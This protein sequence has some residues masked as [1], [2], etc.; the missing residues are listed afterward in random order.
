MLGWDVVPTHTCKAQTVNGAYETRNALLDLFTLSQRK[1]STA[2]CLFASCSLT[3]DLAIYLGL[4]LVLI[5]AST[6]PLI[7]QKAPQ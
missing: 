4:A 5:R 1:K 2:S 6:Q 3:H 7:W